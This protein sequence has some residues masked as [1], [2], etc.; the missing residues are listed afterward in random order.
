M[1][2]STDPIL[3]AGAGLAGLVAANRLHA[4]GYKVIVLE[5]SAE[6]GGRMATRTYD[7]ALFDSGAQ[8]F[9]VREP[10]FRRMVDSWL[11]AGVAGLWSKGF[12]RPSGRTREDGHP[13]Y[14]G[15]PWM[16]SIPKYLAAGLDVRLNQRVE[17]VTV[18]AEERWLLALD[19]GQTVNGR[20]LILTPPLPLSLN[21]LAAGGYTLPKALMAQLHAIEYAPCLA[22][23]VKLEEASKLPPP[24]GLQLH[25][26]PITFIGDN[27]QKGVSPGAFAVTIH[28]GPLFSEEHWETADEVVAELLLDEASYWLGAPVKTWQ[29]DRWR[30]SIPKD[31]V[32]R[33]AVHIP[34][35][36]PL[37]LAGDV[38]G[39]PRVEG[40][41]LSGLAAVEQLLREFAA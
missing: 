15:L 11:A 3:I 30:F 29:L 36:P 7:G 33:R 20:A 24:G 38:F 16:N 10:P 19:K 17:A 14:R 34:G 13:R 4:L 25:G 18:T 40:A 28:A 26:E 35:P 5:E 31:V 12:T 41:A 6:V 23:L 9:T 8:F 27:T 37:V 32:P 21:L 39:G 22:L 1:L 2:H